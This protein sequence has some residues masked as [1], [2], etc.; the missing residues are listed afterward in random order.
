MGK[1]GMRQVLNLSSPFLITFREGQACPLSQKGGQHNP[2]YH[3]RLQRHPPLEPASQQEPAQS[4]G[5]QEA[6]EGSAQDKQ[7]R[8]P[9]RPCF[10]QR[11]VPQPQAMEAG[12]LARSFRR[13]L[14][15]YLLS[16]LVIGAHPPCLHRLSL[17]K[18]DNGTKKPGPAKHFG[19]PAT[20]Y[21]YL[22]LFF[23]SP[24]LSLSLPLSRPLAL[25][26]AATPVARSR[27]RT[28]F[29]SRCPRR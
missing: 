24:S 28:P 1:A 25:I 20:L 19:Q 26:H 9:F 5:T 13:S 3:G 22:F 2:R 17:L 10:P 12:S 16:P 23:L 6:Q 4:S 14:H 21:F 29:R 7:A 27:P 11:Q 15:N 18:D 8:Q